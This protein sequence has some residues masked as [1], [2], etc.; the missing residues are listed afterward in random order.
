MYQS[1]IDFCS[2]GPDSTS[3]GHK[4][5]EVYEIIS[6]VYYVMS[7]EKLFEKSESGQ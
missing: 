6:S 3:S 2:L 1:S 7:V 5:S 4:N